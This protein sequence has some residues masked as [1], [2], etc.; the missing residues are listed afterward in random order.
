M[1]SMKTGEP[2]Y[3]RSFSVVLDG[4]THEVAY[5]AGD[6]VLDCILAAGL[7]PPYLCQE[8]HCGTCMSALRRGQVIMRENLVLSQRDL[9]AGYVLAC[10]SIPVND[11]ELLLDMD[12]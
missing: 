7:D 9:D 6:T 10:Q 12:D 8:G 4:V 3:P 1:S 11:T 2:D 5:T